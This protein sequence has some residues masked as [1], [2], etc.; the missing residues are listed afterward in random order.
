VGSLLNHAHMM[1]PRSTNAQNIADT[2]HDRDREAVVVARV[3]ASDAAAFDSLL[4]RHGATMLRYATALLGTMDDADDVVQAVF[5]RIWQA[6][7]RWRVASTIEAYLV[8]AV[9]HEVLNRQRSRRSA[10]RT[11]AVVRQDITVHGRAAATP[12]D[13]VIADRSE[14]L[15]GLCRLPARRREAVV[16]RYGFGMTASEVAE[17]MRVTPKAVELLAGRGLRALQAWFARR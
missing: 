7:A 13:D 17:V 5:M 15:A 9:R 6:R 8:T 2:A 4:I 16:L 11:A 14:L 12:I 10:D 3:R 1:S